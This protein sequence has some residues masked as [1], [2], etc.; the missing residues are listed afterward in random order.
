MTSP[1]AIGS[2]LARTTWADLDPSARDRWI[3]GLRPSQPDAEVA[4]IL[5]AVRQ[6]GDAALRELTARIDGV[7]LDDLW[8][9]DSEIAEA[10]RNVPRTVLD[11]LEA[12]HAAIRR[13]HADQRDALRPRRVVRTIP[14]VAAWR[15]WVPLRRVGG[16]VPGGRA[17][18]ASSVLMIGVP[19]RLAGVDE[20]IIAT[21]PGL[22]GRVAPAV[23]AA[24]RIAGVDRVLRIGGAQAIAALAFGTASVPRVDR[25]IGAGGAWVTAAKRA[26]A[27]EVAIDLPAGPSECVVV[28]DADADPRLV[29]FDLLAQAEHGPD[30]VAILVTDDAGVADRVESALPSAATE[31]ET[32]EPAMATL[33]ALGRAVLV[34]SLDAAID[35]VEAIAPEH[36]SL[37]CANASELAER[38]RTAGAVFI[39]PWAA[40][41]GGDY[42]FGTNH[43]LPT[44]GAARAWSGVG[45]ETFGRWVEVVDASPSSLRWMA[46]IVDALA[47]AEGLPLHAASVRARLEPAGDAAVDDDPVLLLRRPEPISP[48]P[49]EPSDEALA[50]SVGLAATEILRAD[51]NTLGGGALP[52]ARAALEAYSADD[53]VEYGDLAYAR[54]RTAIAADAGVESKQVVLGAGADEL[55]RLITT[56]TVGAGDAVVIPVPTFPMFAVEAGL[57][58]ARLIEVPR[59]EPSDRQPVDEIR[60]AAVAESARLS[61]M[62]TPNNPTGDAYSVD[63]VR[64]LAEGLG[65][66]VVID[67]VYLDFAAA[68]AGTDI[69][70]LSAIRLQA[71]LPNL[72]VLRSL[73]KSHGLAGARLGYLVVPPALAQTFDG[74]RLPLS[75]SGPAEAM[76]LGALADPAA[77]RAR[78]V[79][80]VTQRRRLADALASRGLEP[81][82]SVTNFVTFRPP[83]AGALAD[84]LLGRGIAVRA[85]ERG[86]LAGWLRITAREAAGTDRIIGALEELL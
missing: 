61:W 82:P 1:T 62:C 31:A 74:A 47:D 17:A 35:V 36:A 79:E 42:A 70:E 84:G 58:G 21:P 48:Y 18:L 65:A 72:L 12:S 34:A 68:D 55:I 57:A 27:G 41:A 4:D 54:L 86:P 26:V 16:Y 25:I 2:V 81:L 44:G 23:L 64:R 56:M 39:G 38:I 59:R 67:E 77:A 52:G 30:S 66:L 9:H 33:R 14:G 11:A 76:A 63:E 37:Q 60:A 10:H 28:A 71:T 19:A 5:A 22:D 45:V 8:V 53:A 51:M 73:A 43:L 50:A 29:A 46:P 6:R 78:H 75:V 13:F 32:G 20:L 15:R 7:E 69:A 40:V 24:A 80:I 83:N 3:A 85:Y 49:A